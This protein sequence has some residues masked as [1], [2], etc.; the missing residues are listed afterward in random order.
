MIKIAV[1]GRHILSPVLKEETT[2]EVRDWAEITPACIDSPVFTNSLAKTESQIEIQ[3][4][5]QYCAH[6]LHAMVKRFGISFPLDATCTRLCRS[7]SSYPRFTLTRS[8]F[9]LCFQTMD[10]MAH[11]TLDEDR[12]PAAGAAAQGRPL[13]GE[14]AAG[15][16]AGGRRARR[17][18]RRSASDRSAA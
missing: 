12:V 15:G 17:D 9:S 8:E 3:I 11:L 18:R 14:P 5:E 7:Y 6:L 1:S 4:C 13:L 2:I 16:G 10:D